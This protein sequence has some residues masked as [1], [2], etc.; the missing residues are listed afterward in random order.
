MLYINGQCN[1]PYLQDVNLTSP[2]VVRDLL[3][4]YG[5]KADKR[6][7]QNFLVERSYLQQIVEAVG[8][9]HRAKR[10]LRWGRAWAP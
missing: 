8:L 5:L 3:E 2:K 7:G 9:T 1:A 10:W 6:F 4:R